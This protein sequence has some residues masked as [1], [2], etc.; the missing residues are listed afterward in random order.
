MLDRGRPRHR[1]SKQQVEAGARRP[2][3]PRWRPRSSRRY[4]APVAMLIFIPLSCAGD[5]RHP[6]GRVRH[7]RRQRLLQAGAGGLRPRGRR[8][9]GG[10]RRQRGHQLLPWR[11]TPTSP[12]SPASARP[13]AEK[14]FV[15]GLLRR[16]DL[17]IFLGLFVLA[18]G[19]RR[20]LS[21]PDAAH[22]HRSLRGLPGH[23]ASSSAPSRL[24]LRE[25]RRC[26]LGRRSSSASVAVVLLGGA[27][28]GNVWMK[29]TPG[30]TVTIEKVQAR[31]LEAIVS[32]SGKIQ[33]RTT[34]N[35]SC[36]HHGP[37]HASWRSTRGRRSRRASS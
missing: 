19:P 30:K 37:R 27:V 11:A 34:V 31:D 28:A 10:R 25:V 17:T 2:P 8:R 35:I 22:L 36:R 29:R 9:H 33:A 24:P 13:F 5:I 3:R 15:A 21:P 20:A 14:G 26:P 23:C 7:H 16:L 4:I 18:I 1:R 6:A 32:A 12:A